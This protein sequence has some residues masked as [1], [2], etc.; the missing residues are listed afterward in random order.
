MA[1]TR[2]ENRTSESAAPPD[3]S[4]RRFLKGVGALVALP[5]LPSLLPR[6]VLAAKR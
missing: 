1:G 3:W 2:R 6:E 5:A 4:R